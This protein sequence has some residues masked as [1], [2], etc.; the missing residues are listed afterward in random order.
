MRLLRCAVVLA[1]L[2]PGCRPDTSAD[3]VFES[4]KVT[5]Y[6][7]LGGDCAHNQCVKVVAPVV[8]SRNG[9]GWCHLYGPGDPEGL[10]PIAE[11]PAL[12]MVPD[13]DTVWEVELPEGAP[14]LRDLN[15]VCDPMMEG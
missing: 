11:S 3:P 5:E 12:E 7:G 9:K 15:P 4:T 2:C 6:Q 10:Q 8:G 13:E 1:V 14:R